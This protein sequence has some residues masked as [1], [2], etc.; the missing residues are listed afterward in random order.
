MIFRLISVFSSDLSWQEIEQQPTWALL[1]NSAGQ[2]II[3]TDVRI[4]L[5]FA[6]KALAAQLK[7]S[8]GAPL[9]QLERTSWFSDQRCAEH[10]VFYIR[11]ERYEFTWSNA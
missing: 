11:P 6:D 9:F 7:V 1:E 3:R 2:S 10:S 5:H 8:K 4:R